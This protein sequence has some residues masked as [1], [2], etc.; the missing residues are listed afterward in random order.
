[1]DLHSQALLRRGVT[2]P[3]GASEIRIAAEDPYMNR[4]IPMKR[5]ILLLPLLLIG[6]SW[7]WPEEPSPTPAPEVRGT[8]HCLRAERNLERMQ[9][10][11]RAGDPMWV[12]RLGEPFHRTCQQAQQ[13]GHS[14]LDPRCVAAARSCAEAKQ[15]PAE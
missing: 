2:P 11:D 6:C 3:A 7:L 9:C 5:L 4:Y 14:F 8:D 13:E 15:C 10:K 12:N 1:M